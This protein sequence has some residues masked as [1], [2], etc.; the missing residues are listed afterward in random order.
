MHLIDMNRKYP[1]SIIKTIV[2]G[3]LL[4]L[5]VFVNSMINDSY[6]QSQS[7]LAPLPTPPPALL[8]TLKVTTKVSGGN[9]MPSDFIISVF[10]NSPKPVRLPVHI[11]VPLSR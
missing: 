10:G 1:S 9:K 6:A 8:G 5:P 7:M 4:L 11:Q 3:T 2:T